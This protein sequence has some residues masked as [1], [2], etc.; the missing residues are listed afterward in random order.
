[1]LFSLLQKSILVSDPVISNSILHHTNL[2]IRSVTKM[3]LSLFTVRSIF[4]PSIFGKK[5]FSLGIPALAI[6]MLAPTAWIA[7]SQAQTIIEI[8]PAADSMAEAE[9]AGMP[10]I[11]MAAIGGYDNLMSD[12]KFAG[13]LAGRP[14]TAN[15][16]EGMIALFTQGRGIVGLDKTRPIGISVQSDGETFA[17]VVCLPINDL[18]S[19][20]G[21]IQEMGLSPF[22]A[23]N[24]ITELELPDQTIYLKETDKWTYVAQSPEALASTPNDPSEVL[25][26]LVKDYDLGVQVMVQNVPEMYRELALEQLRVGMEQGLIRGEEETDEEY[27]LRRRLATI[28]VDQIADLIE[29]IDE[30][31]VGLQIDSNNRSTY[32]DLSLTA[33]DDSDFSKAMTAYTDAKTNLAGFHIPTAAMSMIPSSNNDPAMLEKQRE[34]IE[35]MIQTFRDQGNRAIEEN[36]EIDSEVWRSALK[37]AYDELIDAYQVLVFAEKS[38]G[39]ASVSF[40]GKAVTAI[41]GLHHETPELLVSALKKL[42]AAAKEEPLPDGV[43]T[44]TFAWDTA[45]HAGV[46]LHHI[47]LPLPDEAEL[48][49]LREVVGDSLQLTLGVGKEYAYFAW[50]K[51][52]DEALKIAIDAS[53]S[54]ADTT[55]APPVELFIAMKQLFEFIPQ[56]LPEE[57]LAEF[58]AKTA[59]LFEIESD[60]DKLRVSI[61]PIENGFRLRYEAEEWLLKAISQIATAAAAEQ[62]GGG[63]GGF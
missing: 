28:Q 44:P 59:S 61:V 53:A 38:D 10:T 35:V 34:Q 33:V 42:E 4:G 19:L 12:L 14:E 21:M 41:A 9:A 5:A 8:E 49:Q 50:G 17:P 43:P 46:A 60:S 39:A 32:V 36:K 54:K 57:Q 51:D 47:T 45:S 30:V 48:E 58:E 26:K 13:E 23:G 11:A 1:M 18:A 15:M 24:G 2:S 37:E 27:E 6:T 55:M 22:D 29:G 16:A 31:T 40:N 25:Q 20:L 62:M 52:Q 7:S 63:G 56:F 3:P